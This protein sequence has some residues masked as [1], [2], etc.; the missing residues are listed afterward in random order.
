MPIKHK[1]MTLRDDVVF[2]GFLYQW[3]IYPSDARRPN[4]FGFQY[5]QEL[6]EPEPESPAVVFPAEVV[7]SHD[8]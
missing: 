6:S 7:V 5:E 3:W 2:L 8:D 1:L 4:E